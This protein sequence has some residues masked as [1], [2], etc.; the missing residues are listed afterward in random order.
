IDTICDRKNTSRLVAVLLAGWSK[1]EAQTVVAVTSISGRPGCRCNFHGICPYHRG[2]D[3]AADRSFWSSA[4]DG[5]QDHHASRWTGRV[6]A[7]AL[8]ADPW[9]SLF[10]SGQRPSQLERL[11]TAQQQHGLNPRTRQEFRRNRWR[12]LHARDDSLPPERHSRPW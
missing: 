2:P 9:S 11:V 12:L 1:I 3:Y 10:G 4:H 5:E 8:V 6:G 7:V